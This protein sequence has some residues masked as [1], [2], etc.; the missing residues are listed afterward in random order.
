[1]EFNIKEILFFPPP[2]E[3]LNAERK[4]KKKK[5]KKKGKERSGTKT[6]K[7][8]L[9]IVSIAVPAR[10]D[11]PCFPWPTLEKAS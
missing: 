3:N 6:H 8:H 1:M 10:S 11:A 7:Q 9:A 4:G 2:V 5:G